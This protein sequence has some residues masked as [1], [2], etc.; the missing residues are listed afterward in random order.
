MKF[1]IWWH[2][3]PGE[4][5]AEYI[6]SVT[7]GGG[8]YVQR[9]AR[10]N[11]LRALAP[12]HSKQGYRIGNGYYSAPVSQKALNE[13]AYN[14]ASA[15]GLSSHWADPLVIDSGGTDAELIRC[16]TASEGSRYFRK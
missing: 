12:N 2:R 5:S 13:S 1:W 4:R 14:A 7:V 8:R 9:S 10:G 11:D 3:L 16:L 6:E 15:P